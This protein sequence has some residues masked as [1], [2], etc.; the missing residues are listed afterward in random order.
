MERI[1]DGGLVSVAGIRVGSARCGIK[2]HS[3]QP[4]VA[5]V[6][7]DRPAFAAG[8]FTRNS[9]AAAPVRWCR[10]LLPAEDVRAV[11]INAGNAN[12]C[13][14]RQG[15]RDVRT[16]VE[17]V[18]DLMVAEPEQVLAAST[19]IIGHP[20]PM[21]KLTQG[22]RDAACCLGDE[23]E[24]AR[25]AERAIMTTDTI[26][27]ACAVRSEIDGTPFHVAGMAKGAGMIAPH[28]AT[29]LCVAAT[30]ASVPCAL[31]DRHVRE[32]S[33]LTF[34]RITVDGD[35]ST[36]DSV[37]VLAN[38][39]SG[40]SVDAGAAGEETFRAALQAVLADLAQQVVRDGEGATKLLRV[41]VC[42]AGDRSA[43]ETVARAVAQ[44]QLVRCAVYGGDPNWGRIVCA[45][46]YAG[47]PVEPECVSV[48][49]GAVR[50][51]A[52]G[53]PTA[54][55]ASAQMQGPDVEVTIRLGRGHAEATIQTCDL[56]EDYVRI[57][58]EYHT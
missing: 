6:V 30:D 29:M 15:E 57:N 41:H 22:I 12:A 7:S 5:L 28:M 51:F 56:T 24:F 40:A 26:P 13:T 58:A 44:S 37:I 49:I 35:T 19:G 25:R 8:V 38:G 18:A 2:T 39:A 9:F 16:C 55:N 45:V 52:E 17:L 36:N 47:V 31:L 43:A 34:N 48:D 1:D 32:A 21:D 50:V 33:D 11:V 54:R 20:L 53:R 3:E 14:G 42:E 10:T 23:I 4:D 46:G 27:K